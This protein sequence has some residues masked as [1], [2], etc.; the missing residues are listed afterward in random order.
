MAHNTAVMTAVEML[1]YRV[2]VGDV[3]AQSGL[4]LATAQQGLNALAA[5]TQA[6][7][8]V[9][10]AGEIA[11]EFPKSFRA[12]LRNKYWRLRLQET[13]ERIWSVLFYLIR[14]SFGI[15]LIV[16]I[17]VIVVAILVLVF[18]AQAASQ[19][20]D[21]RGGG[22]SFGGGFG[23]SGMM[24]MP[25]FWIGDLFWLFHYDPYYSRRS[26][27]R[28]A[29]RPNRSGRNDD[30][31]NFLEAIFSFLF[32][33]GDPNA[34][35]EEV[36][37]REIGAVIQN[38]GG[39]IAAE[40]AVPYLDDVGKG[41]AQEDEDYIL[42]VLTRF[43]GVPEVSPRGEIIYHFPELQ[44]TAQERSRTPVPAYLK[45]TPQ[46]F[47]EAKMGQLSGAI[48][49]GTFNFLGAV[50]LGFMLQD[51]ALVAEI[52]GFI[53]VVNAL[54]WVILAYGTA[55]LAVPAVRY[56]WVKRKNSRIEQRNEQ[57]QERALALNAAGPELDQKITFAQQ[58]AAQTVVSAD[59]LAYTT[60]KELTEQEYEQREKL[61]AEWQKRLDAADDA[62]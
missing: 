43:N 34:D 3:A 21:D 53:G 38:N 37:W 6:H 22:S 8:Q 23:G 32:G 33:D 46:K 12:I 44:V 1:D 39:A 35:I 15:L 18:A 11:Y 51:Q 28:R 16:S 14:I 54:Y 62:T 58:F 42:P 26:P 2:T 55:F 47:S 45:E 36:R 29:S 31:M 57:R 52:G 20:D 40:Q 25:R 4:E 56:F 5:D 61:D 17:L 59:D 9:S 60:A 48:A 49:L 27:S 13:W 24:F 10:D 50:V 7:L 30:G 41:W 19:K